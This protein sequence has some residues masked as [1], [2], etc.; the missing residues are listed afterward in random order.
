MKSKILSGCALL[1]ACFISLQVQAQ[2]TLSESYYVNKAKA[3]LKAAADKKGREA[4]VVAVKDGYLHYVIRNGVKTD[5]S[6]TYKPDTLVRI[7]FRWEPPL[8]SRVRKPNEFAELLQALYK[9][10]FYLL[11]LQCTSSGME[12]YFFE[13]QW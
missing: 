4:V 7:P 6:E 12:I 8:R 1:L 9:E 10:K 3:Q 5:Y 13:K 2:A 11:T